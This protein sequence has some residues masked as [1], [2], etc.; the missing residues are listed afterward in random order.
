MSVCIYT[1]MYIYIDIYLYLSIYFSFFLS[2]FLIYLCIYPSIHPYL[3]IYLSIYLLYVCCMFVHTYRYDM[4][5]LFWEPLH[6]S[7]LPQA[8][9]NGS[10]AIKNI[11]SDN[12]QIHNLAIPPCLLV[13]P[14]N[15][16][17]TQININKHDNRK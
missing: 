7:F 16:R 9:L 3:S 14:K 2:F 8:G 4:R 15:A 5:T 17:K 10:R 11:V 13:M 12:G 6:S 1:Y